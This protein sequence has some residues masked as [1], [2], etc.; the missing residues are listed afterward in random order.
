MASNESL[1]TRAGA[2]RPW[3]AAVLWASEFPP[4][5]LTGWKPACLRL[6]SPLAAK[7][8]QSGRAET[9]ALLPALCC[10]RGPVALSLLRPP[11]G[12]HPPR[13]CVGVAWPAPGADTMV[14]TLSRSA[15]ILMPR[16]ARVWLPNE[17]G[18]ATWAWHRSGES[19]TGREVA[20]LF[21]SVRGRGS[22]N[23]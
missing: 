20:S 22:G 3:S 16:M 13:L 11:P 8:W 7:R 6:D 4:L 23:G 5:P 12:S 9:A 14:S 19:A 10:R 18:R 15:W 2:G 17:T 21:A 1:V